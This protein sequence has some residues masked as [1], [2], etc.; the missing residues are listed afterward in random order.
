MYNRSDR[1]LFSKAQC[2][3]VGAF[4]ELTAGYQKKVFNIAF[5]MT[6][7]RIQASEMAQE[8]FV[9]VYRSMKTLDDTALSVYIY[10]TAGEICSRS[11]GNSDRRMAQQV[12]M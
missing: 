12:Q 11:I 5:R 10:R 6:G 7:N 1:E 2:G 3:D 9:R 4:E 8:V